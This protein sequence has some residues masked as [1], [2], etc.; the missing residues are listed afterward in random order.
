MKENSM[1]KV[2][3]NSW[4]SNDTNTHN[5]IYMLLE[6]RCPART[7]W[8]RGYYIGKN[9]EFFAANYEKFVVFC[10]EQGKQAAVIANQLVENKKNVL[11]IINYSGDN[12]EKLRIRAEIM[13]M[14]H[15]I[16]SFG[17]QWKKRHI[18]YNERILVNPIDSTPVLVNLQLDKVD[19][20]SYINVRSETLNYENAVPRKPVEVNGKEIRRRNYL[21]K[22]GPTNN[23]KYFVPDTGSVVNECEAAG[24]AA[25]AENRVI[26]NEAVKNILS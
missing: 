3:V 15:F 11:S 2:K 6:S 16:E 23:Q 20:S 12:A 24:K 1:L 9:S 10:K 25:A 18:L 13:K 5:L 17:L 26:I 4:V 7:I 14:V 22:G 8:E 19:E 21:K